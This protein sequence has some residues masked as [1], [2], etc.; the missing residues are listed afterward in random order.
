M[1]SFIRAA[2]LGRSLHG[3]LIPFLFAWP[4]IAVA[5]GSQ[6][7]VHLIMS[8]DVS[9][10]LT[11]KPDGTLPKD[12]ALGG[13][14][15]LASSA[16]GW[17]PRGQR[18]EYDTGGVCGNA[19]YLVDF[20][21]PAS[22]VDDPA[23][24]FKFTRGSWDTVEVDAKG[25][26]IANHRVAECRTGTLTDGKRVVFVEVAGFADQR[27][28]RWPELQ[29]AASTVTGD[30]RIHE[31]AS[32]VLGNTRKVRVWLP[33]GYGDTG[34]T[35]VPRFPV[36]YMHDGQNCFDAATSFAGE[37]GVD[38][39]LTR[40]IGEGKV[41]SMIVVGIDNAGAARVDELCPVPIG[42]GHAPEQGG[43]GD[44]YIRFI[45]EEVMPLINREYRTLTGP[46]QTSMGGSSLGGV[47]TLHAAMT[48]PE[49]FG[50]I[51]VESPA[52]W[53]GDGEFLK[54]TT[55]HQRW[56]QRVFMAMG[57]KE[58][59]DADKDAE[60]VSQVRG[61]EASMRAAGLNDARLRVVVEDGAGHNEKAWAGR[62]GGAMEFLFG[63]ADDAR[64]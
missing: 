64:P 63:R 42:A 14:F 15:Y 43:K 12:P 30:L 34:G 51:L 48:R 20:V 10:S 22:V 55:S 1:I 37:W 38:E 36:L 13:E 17:N 29:Q 16:N 47:I 32:A 26:D 18:G 35:P 52:L 39:T 60:L 62:L 27:P 54:R 8:Y 33:P 61:V 24:E 25:R 4:S 41:P 23:F 6:E 11:Y 58:Y 7:A 2:S 44:A 3:L 5:R 28:V 9:W 31:V 46:E 40:L 57:G 59:S 49:L 19:P 50:A 21:L 45:V 53:V 56:P